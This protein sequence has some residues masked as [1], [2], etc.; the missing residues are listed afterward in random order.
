MKKQINPNIKAH[1]IR[2]AFYVLLLLAVCV[3]PFALAQRNTTKRSVV[4]KPRATVNLA[5]AGQQARPPGSLVGASQVAQGSARFSSGRQLLG[6]NGA[7]ADAARPG[8]ASKPVVRPAKIKGKAS[9]ALAKHFP[10]GL[11]GN[12]CPGPWSTSTTGPALRYRA[13]ACTD[14]TFVYVYGGG[15]D[16]G[17]NYNDLWRWDPVTE[18]WTQLANMPTAKQNIQGAYADGKIYVP[19]GFDNTSGTHITENA[20]YDIAS[21]TW[22]TGAPLPAPQTGTNV[23]FNGKIYNFGGNP[24]PQSTVT[25]Y[26][27]ATDTWTTGASMPVAITYGRAT[28]AGNFAY[29]AGGIAGATTNTLYRY[30]FAADSWATMSPLQTAR[31]SEELMTSPAGDKLFAVM[32]GDDTFF[33][34]VPLA[35]SV[36]IYDIASDSW[37]YGI[38]V[39]TKAAAPA[40]GLAGGKAMV[41]GGVDNVTYYDIVQVSPLAECGTPTPTPTPGGCQYTITGGTDPIVPG[42]T[43]TGLHTDDGDTFVALPFSFSFCGQTFD[44]VNV[45]TNGRLDFVC[46]NEPV[47]Y[48]TACLPAPPNQCPYDYTIFPLWEDQRTDIGLSGCASFPGGNCGIFTSVS[49]SAPNRIFNIEWRTVLFNDNDATQNYEAR[50]YENEPGKFDVI[51][52]D[53]NPA[54]A[55]HP[56]VSGVQ[57]ASDDFTQDFCIEPPGSPLEFVSRSYTAGGGTP[58]PT[59]TCPPGAPQGGPGP[60]TAGDSY[61]TTIVRYGFV[62]TATDFYVFGGVDNGSTTNAVNRYNIATGSWTSLSPMPFSGEAPTCALMA[63][64]GIV[65]C[66]DGA[67]SNSFASYDIATDTW[68]PLAPDPFTTDHYGSASGAFNGKVFVAGGASAGSLVD[69]YDVAT[70]TWS[71]GTAAPT[72][73]F[74]AGYQQVG[75]FLYVAGGFD[76]T[77]V[78]NATTWR[79]DM[80]SAPGVWDVGP[81]FTPQRADFGLAYDAGT[82]KLYALGGDLPNDGN[83]FNSTNLVDELDLSGW[84]GG[85]W[86]ASPPDLPTPNRQANQA[87]FYGNGDIWSVGGLNGST[88]QFLNEVWHRN[89]AGGGCA[90]PTPTPTPTPG[91]SCPPTITESTSQD[92]IEGGS[93]ACGPGLETHYWRAFDM[94][95][96]TGG[97]E[98]DITSVDFGI[99]LAQSLS[100]TGQPVTVNLYTNSGAPFP[101]GTRTLLAT[102]GPI[103]VPDQSFTIFNV[104]IPATVPAGTLD[105]V[106]EVVVSTNGDVF[107]IGANPD[108]ETRASYISSDACG[109]P[110]PVPVADIGFPNV[111][112]VINVH[113]ICPGGSPTPTPTATATIT[114]PP[115]ATP[116]ATATSTPRPTPTPRPRPTPHPRP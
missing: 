22:T 16:I 9:A 90:S 24:G 82:N 10:S 97:Q 103:N 30:D 6:R 53:L 92:I 70:D 93:V 63:D 64:T 87:G 4:A 107:L 109:T 114:P 37:S 88:F 86:N 25:I 43:D 28:V 2:S 34:G 108:P 84:P 111:H 21:D 29:Y 38:P 48:Q 61:P 113:G 44:G 50:L 79:L 52:G 32:G 59:P 42:D 1:L 91:G 14:G 15:D 47:G 46:V 13:G 66:A 8:H 54:N 12:L 100:G 89:N 58:T 106:M 49:G 31:T 19:G 98:Y 78:N 72:T 104:P 36:E 27:I 62:Q 77:V 116:T 102:S 115:T 99:E 80:S 69:V 96:F 23:A 33:T 35:Q 40:G 17:G 39:V 76:P 60:W 110:D 65:Y 7:G 45:N 51:I 3:I 55:D 101:G 68:T 94:N 81:V 41:Q 18:T 83:F 73:F 105:L 57:G 95:T 56:W 20:I 75:Q 5:A 26:D 11:G 71:P 74:L 85:T 67:T 112:Y